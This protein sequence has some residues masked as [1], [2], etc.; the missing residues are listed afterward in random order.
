MRGPYAV[1]RTRLGI[2]VA[3]GLAVVSI[4]AAAARQTR[5]FGVEYVVE[6]KDTQAQLFHVTARFANVHQPQL[7]LALPVWTPGWY[8]LE[9]YAKNVSHFTATDGQGHRLATPMLHAQTWRIDTRNV[10]EVVVEF[11]YHATILGLNQAFIG[12][13]YAFFTGTQLFLEPVGHRGTSSTVRFALPSGWRVASA[14]AETND[15]Q[16]YRASDYDTLVDAPNWLGAFQRHQ[17]EVEGKPYA[18]VFDAHEQVP[19]EKIS[20]SMA[21]YFP[22]VRAQSRIFGGLPYDKYIEFYL[23]KTSGDGLEHANSFVSE[24][25]PTFDGAYGVGSSHEHFHVWNV[26]RIRPAEMWPYDYSRPIETPSLWVS[27][28]FTDYYAV[29]SDYR[30]GVSTE[31]RLL[32]WLAGQ[33]GARE[34]NDE[35]GNLS[36]S[37]ASV[38][39]WRRY[40]Y[41]PVSYYNA[42]AVLGAIIDLSILGDTRGARGLDDVMRALWRNAYLRNRGFT[43]AEMVQAVSE[44]AGRDYTNFFRRYVTGTE[45][46]PYDSILAFAGLGTS[47][48]HVTIGWI[49]AGLAEPVGEGR[50]VAWVRAESI[51]RAAGLRKDDVIMAVGGDRLPK[52]L[53][54]F[55]EWLAPRAGHRVVFSVLRNG[56][57]LEIPI[58]V[59]TRRRTLYTLEIVADA[60]PKQLVVRQAWLARK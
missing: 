60:T 55:A 14:L 59:P 33:L 20:A 41:E 44:V 2:C 47:E 40:L 22:I 10:T 1:V 29:L 45:T 38:A 7:D 16:V 36:P 39:T 37:D 57:Q 11:D 15:P 35:R 50:R 28:G 19:A 4:P 49:E 48:R 8:I 26:K 17:F 24:G 42:G 31:A 30:A 51:A 25:T 12:S 18:I 23:P 13:E 54:A 58:D 3:V 56:E 43:A 5:A 27:E 21:A 32:Q 46:P 9:Y 34:S 53:F 52:G 6:V